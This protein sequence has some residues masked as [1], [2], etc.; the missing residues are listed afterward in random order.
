MGA[1]AVARGAEGGVGGVE[2]GPI[3]RLSD[4]L[5]SLPVL[6]VLWLARV[7]LLSRL[8]QPVGDP[9]PLSNPI[10]FLY[11][12]TVELGLKVPVEGLDAPPIDI[13]CDAREH[14]HT[15]KDEP[16]ICSGDAPVVGVVASFDAIRARLF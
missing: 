6:C 5:L 4:E 16:S 11:F 10:Y 14:S 7:L 9:L 12:H 13:A 8:L 2:T 3:N 1:H 15:G